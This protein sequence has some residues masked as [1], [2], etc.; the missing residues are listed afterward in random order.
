MKKFLFLFL[1][2]CVAYCAFSAEFIEGRIKLVINENNGRFSLYYMTDIAQEEF[3]PFFAAE[4]P[5]TSFLSLILNNRTYKMGETSSFKTV[6]G[7]TAESPSL[8]FESPFFVI[9]QNFSFIK[10]GSSSLANGVLITITIVNKSEQTV[11]AGLRYLIDTDL[12]EKNPPHFFTNLR[13][14]NNETIIDGLSSEQYWVSKNN[15]LGLV[16]SMSGQNRPDAVYFANWKRLHDAPWKISYMAGRNFNLLPY[17]IEDSAVCYY[18]ESTPIPKGGSRIASLILSVADDNILSMDFEN[19][20]SRANTGVPSENT[21][22]DD[23]FAVS[24]RSD[25]AALTDLSARLDEYII[26][27]AYISDDELA[28][29]SLLISRI[30]LK[31]SIP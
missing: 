1:I 2:F 5:R 17:S 3:L 31:Y 12:G 26:S 19:I 8:I 16:G 13:Q 27:G 11:D 28:A 20:A 30:K 10:T 29:I 15:K 22:S 23:N 9:T 21:K 14:I 6:L 7:G 25:L 4:D 18:Y 24:I